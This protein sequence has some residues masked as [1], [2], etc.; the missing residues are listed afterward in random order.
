MGYS[1]R[2]DRYRF[3][4]WQKRAAGAEIV[5]M[6]LYDHENDPAENVNVAAEPANIAIV[7]EL[8]AQLAATVSRDTKP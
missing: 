7:E 5:A 1:M 6:E 2:T 8:K 3:T 4:L